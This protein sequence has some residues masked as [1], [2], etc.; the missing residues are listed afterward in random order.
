M[1][2]LI[3][4]FLIYNLP[5]KVSIKPNN[6]IVASRLYS[7]AHK[8]PTRSFRCGGGT[9]AS[10]VRRRTQAQFCFCVLCLLSLYACVLLCG[11]NRA[12]MRAQM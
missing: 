4:L 10:C 1:Y 8:R 11:M 7:L 2:K 5:L 3:L 9:R 6:S 12:V